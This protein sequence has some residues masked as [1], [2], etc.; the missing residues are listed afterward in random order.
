MNELATVMPLTHAPGNAPTRAH[1]GD[2]GLDL[3]AA[4]DVTIPVGDRAL[5]PT[6]VAVAMPEGHVGMVCPRSGLAARHGV[7]VL[8]APG[9]IDAGYRGDIGVVLVNHGRRRVSIEKGDRIAQLVLVPVTIPTLRLVDEL[10]PADD[11]RDADGF[12]STGA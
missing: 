9:I 12:G 5:V 10:P 1:A 2:A 4:V 6:G 11:G 3:R 8:N 7:T